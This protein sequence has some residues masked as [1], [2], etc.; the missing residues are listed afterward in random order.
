MRTIVVGALAFVAGAA[1]GGLFVRWYVMRHAGQLAGDA[2][3]AELFGEGST[4]AKIMGGLLTG[5]DEIRTQ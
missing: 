2:I 3:G 1:A 4:G 5:L